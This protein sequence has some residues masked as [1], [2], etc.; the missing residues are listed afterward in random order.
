MHMR[1]HMHMHMSH[2]HVHVH[3]HV[4]VSRPGRRFPGSF[5]PAR[6]AMR[7]PA[8]VQEPSLGAANAE[9]V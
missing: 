8:E 3:V 7:C 9:V 2:A 1:M 6:A 4:H 5:E